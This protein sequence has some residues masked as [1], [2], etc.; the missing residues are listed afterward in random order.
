LQESGDAR[1]A[2]VAERQLEQIEQQKSAAAAQKALEAKQ[3]KEGEARLQE[4]KEVETLAARQKESDAAKEEAGTPKPD[5]RPVLFMKGR[6]VSVDCSPAP[7]AVLTIVGDGKTWK[8]LAPEAKNLVVMGNADKLSCS[9][10]NQKVAVNY[11]KTG[12]R[13][14]RLVSLELQ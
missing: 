7:S 13:E 8:M 6:L 11:R 2:G 5:K 14:G 12:E 1:V 10:S 9:W 4:I 3:E